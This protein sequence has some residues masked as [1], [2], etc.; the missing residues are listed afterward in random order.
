MHDAPDDPW[1]EPLDWSRE[2]DA[3]PPASLVAGWYDLF[4]PGQVEDFCRLRQAGRRA[5]LTIGPWTHMSARGGAASI[6]DGLDWFDLHLRGERGG[7]K[8]DG[9]RLYVTGSG[10]WVDLPDWPPP[11]TVQRWHLQ[12]G[13]RLSPGAPGGGPPDRYAYDPAHP[14]PGL[15]GPSLDPVRAGRRNQR[16]R[17]SRPDVLVYSS[18]VLERDVTVVGPVNAEI[19]LRCDRPSYDVFVRLCDVDPSGRSHNVCDGIVRVNPTE[20]EGG[21]DRPARVRVALW[22]T[23]HTFRAGHRVRV[24]MSSAA[25]P[26]YARNPGSAE[27]LGEAASLHAGEQEV[28][29][30]PDRPSCIELPMST[31]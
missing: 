19:W 8:A 28:F 27:S 24:Q 25:H 16:R 29:H 15:G 30:D 4:L 20:A 3:T 14:A 5:R 31:I 11:S 9:V 7:G 1:W 13:Y 10:R 17:E 12:P 21:G 6:R 2:L 23:A 22:P 18:A 26:L